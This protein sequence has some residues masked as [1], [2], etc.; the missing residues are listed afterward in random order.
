M[1]WWLL[2]LWK[3]SDPRHLPV[4][5]EILPV[6][7]SLHIYSFG[8]FVCLWFFICNVFLWI[9]MDSY[10]TLWIPMGSHM[11]AFVFVPDSCGLPWISMGPSDVVLYPM[12]S[13]PQSRLFS[14]QLPA[15]SHSC[16]ISHTVRDLKTGKRYQMLQLN[17]DELERNHCGTPM[18]LH[19]SSTTLARICLRISFLLSSKS[20]EL[21]IW[22]A[23]QSTQLPKSKCFYNVINPTVPWCSLSTIKQLPQHCFHRGKGRTLHSW[24]QWHVQRSAQLHIPWAELKHAQAQ[25]N[26]ASAVIQQ[27]SKLI[28][29]KCIAAAVASFLKSS[30]CRS[31]YSNSL[32]ADTS[33]NIASVICGIMDF[34]SSR[35]N[36]RI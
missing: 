29:L 2:K 9:P 17:W 27:Q 8:S 13:L 24:C 35:Y 34:R 6:I 3:G 33:W 23:L 14:Q 31:V 26:K 19:N 10:W 15:L 12:E 36:G 22:V 4:T 20:M 18:A 7:W 5:A 16:D 25:D 1:I 32:L 21:I 11:D 30:Y 28:R